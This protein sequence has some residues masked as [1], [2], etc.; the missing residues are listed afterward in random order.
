MCRRSVD[1]EAVMDH[2]RYLLLLLGC[3]L[4][5]LPLEFV[6]DARVYRRP[7]RLL[8]A[9]SVPLVVFCVWDVAGIKRGVWSY[10]PA[11]VTGLRLPFS[12]P[13]EE[14]LFFL[15]IPVCGLLTYEAVGHVLQRLRPRQASAA[16]SEAGPPDA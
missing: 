5:T 4:V 3:V 9:L 12:L 7:R 11:F 1:Q 14:F 13:I 10:N 8:A 16:R 2:G 6:F 15:V